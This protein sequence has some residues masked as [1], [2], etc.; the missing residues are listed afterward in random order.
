MVLEKT[1][2]RIQGMTCGH[3]QKFVNN[4]LTKLDGVKNVD[5]NL[6]NASASIEFDPE[7][8]NVADIKNAI[9]NT[10]TYKAL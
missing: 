6:Q 9:N 5:I 3:C 7:K 4:L 8:I 2:I 1:E 10:E